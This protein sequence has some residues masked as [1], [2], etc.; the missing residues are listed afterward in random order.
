MQIATSNKIYLNE[1]VISNRLKYLRFDVSGDEKIY[2]CI[3]IY[4]YFF[5]KKKTAKRRNGE[6]AKRRRR[7]RQRFY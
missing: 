4:V 7:R 2:K 1:I 5:K 3:F 6:T